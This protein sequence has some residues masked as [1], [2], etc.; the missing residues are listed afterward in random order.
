MENGGVAAS[1]P[2]HAAM[3][4]CSWPQ[5]TRCLSA[6][7]HGGL[8]SGV[9]QHL[10]CAVLQGVTFTPE[11]YEK[12]ISLQ[13][14][15]HESP[16]CNKREAAAIGTH[17]V[18]KLQLPLHYEALSPADIKFVPLARD[19]D[20]AADGAAAGDAAAGGGAVGVGF[21]PGQEITA[22]QLPQ[23]FAGDKSMLRWGG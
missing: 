21:K 23:Y 6:A 3:Q 1:I 22:E 18:A 4:P 12:F 7:C 14:S 2:L 10:V 19:K 9:R 8:L 5:C 11:L 15:I 20:A 17:D 13:T 16:L